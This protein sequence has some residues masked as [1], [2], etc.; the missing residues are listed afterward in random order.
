MDYTLILINDIFLV[1]DRNKN[2]KIRFHYLS[3]VCVIVWVMF[4]S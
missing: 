4:E 3:F 2:V 1:S